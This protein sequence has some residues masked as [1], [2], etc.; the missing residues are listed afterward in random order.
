[1][2][3]RCVSEQARISA[4]FH[5][6]L[7]RA[8]GRQHTDPVLVST[9]DVGCRAL[10]VYAL[11]LFSV[12]FSEN[13]R[14]ISERLLD[15]TGRRCIRLTPDPRPPYAVYHLYHVPLIPRN[16]FRCFVRSLYPPSRTR[17]WSARVAQEPRG[18]PPFPF[19][20]SQKS[21]NRPSTVTLSPR[22]AACYSSSGRE[23]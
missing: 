8:A 2:R 3:K 15:G 22:Y 9:R 10:V 14:R 21:E 20:S 6:K 11:N 7:R 1:M 23:V 4:R 18:R 13:S 19:R 5:P 12:Q 17:A 16:D